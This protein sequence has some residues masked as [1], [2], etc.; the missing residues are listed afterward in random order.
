VTVRRFS[1]FCQVWWLREVLVPVHRFSRL[2]AA[3]SLLSLCSF[4]SPGRCLSFLCKEVLHARALFVCPLLLGF[5][6]SRRDKTQTRRSFTHPVTGRPQH[7]SNETCRA[8]AFGSC[9][10]LL[11]APGGTFDLTS[12]RSMP[13]LRIKT[14]RGELSL[15]RYR[16]MYVHTFCCLRCRAWELRR[17]LYYTFRGS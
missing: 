3:V 2:L 8:R 10:C 15:S 14:R 16:R 9:S 4:R 7:V 11:A 13:K 5:S 12:V 6:A 1:L 17:H